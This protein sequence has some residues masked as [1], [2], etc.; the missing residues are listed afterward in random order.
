M[1]NVF[2]VMMNVVF[3]IMAG[4]IFSAVI[5]YEWWLVTFFIG[6]VLWNVAIGAILLVA[7]FV[8]SIET[9]GKAE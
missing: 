3:S 2:I 7:G 8:L 5:G 6:F 1:W 4:V 9:I